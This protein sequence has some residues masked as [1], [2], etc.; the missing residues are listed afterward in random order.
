LGCGLRREAAE[1]PEPADFAGFT[2]FNGRAAE[3]VEVAEVEA[4]AGA[5]A[6]TDGALPL[7]P[8]RFSCLS[9]RA[10]PPTAT[11]S[12]HSTNPETPRAPRVSAA[13]GVEWLPVLK[14]RCAPL[15]APFTPPITPLSAAPPIAPAASVVMVAA[16]VAA[17]ATFRTVPATAF[18]GIPCPSNEQ[19]G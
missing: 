16:R 11:S 10:V 17:P 18:M 5:F 4:F 14:P 15:A 12:G 7:P 9:T 13:A 19:I 1:L 6:R 2:D 8:G 3:V